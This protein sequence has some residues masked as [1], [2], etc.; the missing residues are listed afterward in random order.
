QVNTSTMYIIIDAFPEFA[1]MKMLPFLKA[2]S[3][4]DSFEV[5]SDLNCHIHIALGFQNC[6]KQISLD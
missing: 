1:A 3:L 6:Y 2:V 4:A 5:S